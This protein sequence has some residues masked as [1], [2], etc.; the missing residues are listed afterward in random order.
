VLGGLSA[1]AKLGGPRVACSLSMCY[2]F[3]TR[4]GAGLHAG[5]LCRSV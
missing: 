4:V 5:F 3:R 1:P 2:A